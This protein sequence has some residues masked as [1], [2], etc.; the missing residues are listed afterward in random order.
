MKRWRVALALALCA[1]LGAT[2]L[3]FAT[4]GSPTLAEALD[5]MSLPVEEAPGEWEL[6]LLAPEALEDEPEP[7]EQP[8]QELP[9]DAPEATQAPSEGPESTEVP[10]EEIPSDDPET[11][12]P[13]GTPE[14]EIPAH[15]LTLNAEAIRLGVKETFRLEPALSGAE[16]VVAFTFA[17]SDR[18]VATVSRT[19]KIRAK[20]RGEA[21]ITVTAPDGQA[22]QCLVEVVKAPARLKLNAKAVTLA[23]DEATGAGTGFQLIPKLSRG[24]ASRVRYGGYD[25][26]VLRV[27]EGG[28]LRAVGVGVTKVTARTFNR[29]KAS[30]TV[31]VLPAPDRIELNADALR[32]AP[33]DRFTL[34]AAL[35]EDTAGPVAFRSDAPQVVRADPETGEIVALGVGEA[36]VIAE[37]FNGVAARCAVSVLPPP[38]AIALKT[39]SLRLGVGERFALAP[40]LTREDGQAAGGLLSYS[41]SREKVAA[42]D[43][44]GVVIGNRRGRTRVTVTGP[45][46]AKASCVVRVKRAPTSIQL[47]AEQSRLYWDPETGQGEQ[48][49]LEA[50]LSRGAASAIA[51]SGYDPDVVAV[52]P[53]GRVTAV[54]PGVTAITAETYNGLRATCAIRVLRAGQAATVNVAHRGGAGYW[55]ENTLE[56][57][58]KAASTGATAIELDAR[59]TRDGVQVVH[60]DPTITV[61]G[62]KREIKKLTLKELRALKPDLCTLDEAVELIA[63][64]GLELNLELKKTA[65]PEACVA[66]VRRFGMEGRT[67]YISFEPSLL[68]RVRRAEPSAR[69]GILMTDTRSDVDALIRELSLGYV[70][71]R[72]TGLTLEN[73]RAWQARGL[74]VGVWTID[75][76]RDVDWW[77]AQGVDYMTSNY[78]RLVTASLEDD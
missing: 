56:A 8:A 53:E 47:E 22:V 9:P 39:R 31:T 11:A 49:A 78:P 32:L 74:L 30:V 5:P 13:P 36:V 76:R 44:Q 67:V 72:D 58:S 59:T 33:G 42:V 50:T 25:E 18:K 75:D 4:L 43:P 65:D 51:Y 23:W 41:S 64:T 57:F 38:D 21:R 1:A 2:T 15:A 37:C 24:S 6:E 63:G 68:Q 16:G 14:P 62:R 12:E 27:D 40:A 19:G 3:G 34:S 71:Q 69:M 52:S 61:G 26:A 66:S 17:T 35:P 29:K 55:P 48:T 46:G 73:L 20:A 7:T 10:V 54:G 45:G 77:L 28:M 60:H 70:F